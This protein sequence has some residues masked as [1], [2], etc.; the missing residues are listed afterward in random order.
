MAL[1]S[2]KT[3]GRA[4][5]VRKDKGRWITV[6]AEFRAPEPVVILDM[7][8]FSRQGLSRGLVFSAFIPVLLK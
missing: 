8:V 7:P 4:S 6:G 1:G 5:R 2:L 3:A